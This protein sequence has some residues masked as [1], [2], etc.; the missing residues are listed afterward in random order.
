VRLADGFWDRR[1]ETN[2]TV[3]IPYV[4]QRCEETGLIDNFRVAAK[5]MAGGHRGMR[6]NDSDV[7]KCLEAAAHSLADHPD[8][9]LRGRVDSLVELVGAAQEPDGY[10]YTIR[11]IGG[12]MPPEVGPERWSNL[13]LSHELYSFG[14]LYEAAAALVAGPGGTSLLNTALRNFELV[15]AV[16]GPGR[17]M[18]VPGHQEIELALVKLHALTGDE[19]M[20]ET[21]R[22]FVDQR[23]NA[24]GH[25]LYTRYGLVDFCQDHLPVRE[26]REAVGH[27][28]RS[29]Y[30][31]AGMCD[32]AAVADVTDYLPVLETLWRN[33]VG[34]KMYLTG[35]TG[36]RHKGES[37]GDD[38]ELPSATGYAETCAS[39]AGVLWNHRMFLQSGEARFVDVLERILY[40]GLLAGVSLAGDR[41]FYTNPLESDGAW[42]F[43]LNAA[44]TRNPWFACPCCPTNVA[45]FM[46]TVSGYQY[47]V[48]GDTLSVLLYA[49]GSAR[50]NVGGAEVTVTQETAM[51]WDGA[52][53]L[54]VRSLHP[55][56]FTLALRVPG[57][58]RGEAIPLGLYRF[59]DSGS[60]RV[61]VRVNGDPVV[62]RSTDGWVRIARTWQSG[63]EVALELPMPVQRVRCD[64]RVAEN[65]DRVAVQRG[66]LVYCAEWADNRE[67]VFDLSIRDE[68]RLSLSGR[69]DLPGGARGIE[70]GR[71]RATLIPYFSWSH[72]GEG[73]MRVWLKREG[74]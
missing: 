6:V 52:V 56:S 1:I 43:N 53:R 63:D 30:L 51:P 9:D 24:A 16:F 7:F 23:G 29:Q 64:E 13:V 46:P 62:P 67:D 70:V 68:D 17:H 73:K 55:A 38:F 28:V 40:N 58:A 3:T 65:R 49:A 57:W 45:R 61:S 32:L 12:D 5:R 11:T 39:V 31:Y 47:A 50:V 69:D 60:T 15:H 20:L 26:Q 72:R 66:P 42:K 34:R 22:F 8:P 10:L 35:G 54:R 21:A 71:R 14:H 27:A 74:R 59:A 19:R 37:F 2:R 4:L 33:V 18:G 36:S 41:F 48:D 25:K 44:A